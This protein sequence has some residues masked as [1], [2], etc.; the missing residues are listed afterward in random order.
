[1]KKNR[2]IPLVRLVI[3]CE[4]PSPVQ[5]IAW[6]KLLAKLVVTEVKNEGQN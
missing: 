4:R 6:N 2:P 5:K 1:M 3:R